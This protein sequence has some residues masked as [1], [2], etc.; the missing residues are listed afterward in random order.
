M[1]A[2]RG[3]VWLPLGDAGVADGRGRDGQTKK[4]NRKVVIWLFFCHTRPL[5]IF[6]LLKLLLLHDLLHLPM[7]LHNFLPHLLLYNLC[8]AKGR[9][10][11]THANK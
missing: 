3:W 9:G 5:L 11:A 1:G 4:V 7:N 8:R 2:R 6:L 10:R